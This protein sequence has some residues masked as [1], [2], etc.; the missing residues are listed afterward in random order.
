MRQLLGAGADIL[1]KDGNGKRPLEILPEDA[2]EELK[3]LIT[4]L[5]TRSP[6]P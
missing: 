3:R 4:W 5:P 6:L 1:I 2:S